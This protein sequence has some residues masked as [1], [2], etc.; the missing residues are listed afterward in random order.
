MS[1]RKG[2]R[3]LLTDGS[4]R[5]LNVF[6]NKLKEGHCKVTHSLLVSKIV[7]V[8]ID[9]YSSKE[10]EGFEKEFFDQK[11]YLKSVLSGSMSEE[12]ISISMKK[13]LKKVE[14]KRNNS[15]KEKPLV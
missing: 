15:K 14:Q 12:E 4:L 2:K 10:R 8:F 1:T 11:S 5:K 9:K 13:F 6:E 7:E 3:I